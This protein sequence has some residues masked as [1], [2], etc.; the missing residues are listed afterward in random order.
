MMAGYWYSSHL[1]EVVATAI[2]DWMTDTN[3]SLTPDQRLKLRND[4]INALE[5]TGFV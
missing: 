3:V 4:I 5:E 2:E 1:K